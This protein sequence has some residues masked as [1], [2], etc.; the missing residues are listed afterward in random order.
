MTQPQYF[1]DFDIGMVSKYGRYEVTAEEII[2]FASKYDPQSFHLTEEAGKAMHFGGLCASGLHTC[3]MVMRM[4]VDSMVTTGSGSL[5]SPGIDELR[6]KK[7]VYPGDILRLESNVVDKRESRSRPDMG[8]IF[9]DNK[10]FN[11]KD[12]MVM[13]FKP[14]VMYQRRTE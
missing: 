12:E 8:S 3:A 10:V 14:I 6:W 7:P 9:L 4:V 13:S 1:E 2:E 5:G 11:Q